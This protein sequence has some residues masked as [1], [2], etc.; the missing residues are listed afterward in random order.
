MVDS[1]DRGGHG[2][3]AGAPVSVRTCGVARGVHTLGFWFGR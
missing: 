1:L 3:Y 2:E